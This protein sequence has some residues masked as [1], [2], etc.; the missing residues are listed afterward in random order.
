MSETT[1][2]PPPVESVWD[3]ELG[4]WRNYIGGE[5]VCGLYGR[6]FAYGTLDEAHAAAK[7][8]VVRPVVAS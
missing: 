7:K 5:P 1:T 4:A 6:P 8:V 2:A 3:K